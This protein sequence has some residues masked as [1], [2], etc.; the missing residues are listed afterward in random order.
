MTTIMS[1]GN[2]DGQRRC[3]AR[4]YNAVPGDCDCICGGRNHGKGVL[5]AIENN[6]EDF[7]KIL[8]EI[9]ARFGEGELKRHP[10]QLR[11]CR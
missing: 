4:C 8:H 10:V 5:K 7:K 3:D 2:S 1:F 11:F 9:K 6:Q